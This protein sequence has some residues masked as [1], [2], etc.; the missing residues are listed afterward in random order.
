MS[1]WKLANCVFL[2][3][4]AVLMFAVK[5]WQAGGALFL[6]GSLSTGIRISR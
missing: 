4:G 3:A 1:K 2:I 6:A 5:P